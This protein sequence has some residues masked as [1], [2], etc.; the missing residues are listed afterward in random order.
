MAVH[1]NPA[2]VMGCLQMTDM[3][4]RELRSWRTLLSRLIA[5]PGTLV[6]LLSFW[7]VRERDARSP[8]P[9]CEEPRA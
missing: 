7:H 5:L 3:S 1:Y 4:T 6:G 2:N 9:H 8:R